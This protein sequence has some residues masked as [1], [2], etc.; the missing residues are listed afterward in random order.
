VVLR[1]THTAISD[2]R[3]QHTLCVD[4]D[5]A[6]TSHITFNST[7]CQLPDASRCPINAPPWPLLAQ[8]LHSSAGA[9]LSMETLSSSTLNSGRD[10][11]KAQI[12]KSDPATTAH[13]ILIHH[14]GPH[15]SAASKSRKIQPQKHGSVTSIKR[16]APESSLRLIPPPSRRPLLLPF[17]R[18]PQLSNSFSSFSLLLQC[19]HMTIV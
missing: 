7:S 6:I 13:S 2:I 12:S 1:S 4:T 9:L 19:P 15:P 14:P 8:P 16:L 3:A 10:T 17:S 5:T 11:Q 18:H